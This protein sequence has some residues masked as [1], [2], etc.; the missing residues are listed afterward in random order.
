MSFIYREGFFLLL[1]TMQFMKKNKV[2]HYERSFH[3]RLEKRAVEMLLL[4]RIAWRIVQ[5]SR[6][7]PYGKA[8]QSWR[9]HERVRF[10]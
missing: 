6:T 1:R 4:S 3:R 2:I 9:T 10:T 5:H 7:L 8:A